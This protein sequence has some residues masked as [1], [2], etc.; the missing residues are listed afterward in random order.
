MESD[1]WDNRRI[2]IQILKN[3]EKIMSQQDDLNQDEQ[4]LAQALSDVAGQTT[5]LGQTQT[6]IA[7]EIASLQQANP[8]LDL[9]ALDGLAQSAAGTTA[10]LDTAVQNLA[11]L[12][13][14][15]S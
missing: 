1:Y 10:A 6:Q 7:Q 2:L 9:T 13:P 11:G 12:A 3:T 8:S 15:A 5:A 14:A 4:L